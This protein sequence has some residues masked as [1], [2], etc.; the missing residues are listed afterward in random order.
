[1]KLNVRAKMLG[2]TAAFLARGPTEWPLRADL[3]A[4]FTPPLGLGPLTDPFM[5]SIAKS[6]SAP[7]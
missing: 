1:M 7:G 4:P 2:P 6:D 3:M 5:S